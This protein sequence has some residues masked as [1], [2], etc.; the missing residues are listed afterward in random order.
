MD[1]KGMA[2]TTIVYSII[3]LL[4]ITMLLTLSILR[5]QYNNE[6]QFVIDIR[7]ELNNYLINNKIN[8]ADT[9]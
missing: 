7:E 1:N 8:I 6:K 5:N 4:S 3:L 2:I 9:N